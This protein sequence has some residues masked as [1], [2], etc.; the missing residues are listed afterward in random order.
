MNTEKQAPHIGKKGTVKMEEKHFRVGVI[1]ICVIVVVV[2]ALIAA[3][4]CLLPWPSRF[5]MTM[6]AVEITAEGEVLEEG[7]I[8]LEAWEYHYLLK[9]NTIKLTDME[10]FDMDISKNPNHFGK[11][12]IASLDYLPAFDMV[13]TTVFEIGKGS[14]DLTMALS[15]ERDWCFIQLDGKRYFAAS[16]QEN[17]DPAVILE[18]CAFLVG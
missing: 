15:K 11:A 4:V 8:V 10:F 18:E 7:Q 13:Y 3:M 12:I 17:F 5:D 1:T 6:N 9:D 2:I 14:H 16:V